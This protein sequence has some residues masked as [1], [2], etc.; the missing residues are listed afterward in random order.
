MFCYGQILQ[1][2]EYTALFSVIGNRFGG[3]GSSTF[4]LPNLSGRV[5]MGTGSGPGLTSRSI[6]HAEG[7]PTVVLGTQNLPPHTHGPALEITPQV[8]ATTDQGSVSSPA[9]GAVLASGY[10]IEQA[11]PINL[12]TSSSSDTMPL[13]GTSGG[14]H[15]PLESTGA[16][17]AH[18]NMMPFLAIN[19]I[20]A[21]QGNYPVR[22]S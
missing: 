17:G 14:I 16:G 18:D 22:P 10:D 15:G 7:T 1:I 21:V 9:N 5:A 13:S 6:G 2:Q 11:V 8:R 12:Y 19:Y 3:N 4:A 20:I